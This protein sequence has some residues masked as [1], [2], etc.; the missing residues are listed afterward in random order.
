MGL[1][2]VGVNLSLYQ[3]KK[4]DSQAD[5]LYEGKIASDAIQNAMLFSRKNEMKFAMTRDED[6]SK[7]VT[8]RMKELVGYISQLKSLLSNERVQLDAEQ[9]LQQSAKYLQ[10]FQNL[11]QMF[12]QVDGYTTDM[13]YAA[14]SF[15]DI[16][17]NKDELEL[18]L[19][20]YELRQ[21]EKDYLLEHDSEQ[22]VQFQKTAASVKKMITEGE[23]FNGSIKDILLRNFLKYTDAFGKLNDLYTQQQE[24]DKQFT[25][26]NQQMDTQV[27]QLGSYLKAELTAIADHKLKLTTVLQT[28]LY[29]L[30][31]VVILIML[32]LGYVLARSI[33]KSILTLKQ[34]AEI[35]GS[36]NLTYRV[37]IHSLDEMGQLAQTFNAMAQ[38][39]Q[40]SFSQVLEVSNKLAFS[41]QRLAAIS[42]ETTAHT[43]DTN[44]VIM[45][46]AAATDLQSVK[47]VRG[48]ELLEDMNQQIHSVHH[49]AH[50]ISDQAMLSKEKGRSGLEKVADLEQAYEEYM[51]VASQLF[52]NVQQ[53]EGSFKQIVRV[54]RGIEEISN[55]INMIALNA[56]IE[57]AR[58]GSYGRGFAVVAAE[59][60]GLAD[61]AKLET[62]QIAK[63]SNEM[64]LVMEKL[65]KGVRQLEQGGA[66][67]GQAVLQT[68]ASFAD[69]AEQNSNITGRISLIQQS[70]GIVT[71]S[72]A[73]LVASMHIVQEIS[74]QSTAAT[75]DVVESSQEQFAAIRE[76]SDSAQELGALSEQLVYEVEQFKL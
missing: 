6:S 15:D 32:G 58:A 1:L 73:N 49:S 62:L 41:S 40:K 55:E 72:S 65:N 67:Q 22:A 26:V 68:R 8:E 27:E 16:V 60:K 44:S 2:S 13:R 35:I 12:Q 19:R 18:L 54:I 39:V 25:S 7:A 63:V 9:L 14:D 31:S 38:G 33:M 42:E 45:Q 30:S 23:A 37:P 10:Q 11:V 71:D 24:M 17:R 52:T 48:I 51:K 46:I 74:N 57:A 5:R 47:L 69:I 64:I 20:M 76:V 66:V 4:I 36:G 29:L 50:E 3:L 56:T 61:K 28:I 21:S 75:R 53:V 34:G 70:L 43:E 59:V